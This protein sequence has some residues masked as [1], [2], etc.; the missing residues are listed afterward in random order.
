MASLKYRQYG[1]DEGDMGKFLMGCPWFHDYARA[2]MGVET[3]HDFV[4]PLLNEMVRSGATEW[5][6]GRLMPCT[7]YNAPSRVWYPL[8]LMPREWGEG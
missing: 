2:Y 8:R 6:N 1:I 4:E 7:A 5:R 3:P